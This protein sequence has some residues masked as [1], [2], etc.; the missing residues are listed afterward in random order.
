MKAS[1]DLGKVPTRTCSAAGILRWWYVI[2]L[3]AGMMF[4]PANVH[5]QAETIVVGPAGCYTSSYDA[6]YP[7]IEAAV[8]AAGSNPDTI[9]VCDGTYQEQVVVSHASNL[10]IE[11]ENPYGAIVEPPP[12]SPTA[13]VIG[14][15]IHVVDSTG[16]TLNGFTVTGANNFADRCN[17]GDDRIAGI[18]YDDSTGTISGNKVLDIKHSDAGFYGCQEGIG[19][20]VASDSDGTYTVQ[21]TNNAIMNYQKGGIV[22]NMSGTSATIA[23]NTIQGFGQT[24]SIAQNGIQFG[25]GASGEAR[26]NTISNNWYLGATWTA[27]GVILFDVDASKVK[28]SLNKFSGVQ[29]NISVVTSQACPEEHGGFYQNYDLCPY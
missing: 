19:I 6:L 4:W 7:T 9:I 15:V 17:P 14:P 23:G 8:T 20:W 27:G 2:V 1:I 16:V 28:H 29:T 24:Y 22:V 3:L 25:F 26:N 21:I 5:A 18:R 11:A 13:P 12:S 10:T